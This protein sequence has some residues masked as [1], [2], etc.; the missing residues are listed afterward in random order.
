MSIGHG[1]QILLSAA[2][3]ALLENYY[4]NVILCD[5]LPD[6]GRSR[7]RWTLTS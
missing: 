7:K 6:H 2:V 5:K 3:H 4:Y 1:G